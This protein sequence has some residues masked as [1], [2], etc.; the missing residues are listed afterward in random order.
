MAES[1][2]HYQKLGLKCG[3]EI[4]QQLEGKKLF[5]SCPTQLRDDAPHFTIQRKI[6]AV[7]GES[8]EV[9]IAAK[10]E[11]QRDKTFVYEGYHDTTCL[12]EVDEEPPHEMNSD[13]LYRSLIPAI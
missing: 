7:A 2:D 12:V 13:A 9:D 4:H 10:Q 3:I 5:C 11:Q 8:G 6:R 1:I